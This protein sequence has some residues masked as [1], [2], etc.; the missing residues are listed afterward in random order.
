MSGIGSRALKIQVRVTEAEKLVPVVGGTM[1]LH[2]Q[3]QGEC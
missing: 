2:K 1:T 3:K